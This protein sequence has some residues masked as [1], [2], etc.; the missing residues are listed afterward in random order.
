[1]NSKQTTL[2]KLILASTIVL[3][4]FAATAQLNWPSVT[5]VTKPWTRWWWE[6]SAVNKADLTWNLEQYQQAGLGGVELTPIYGVEGTEKQF[7]D[8]LS[9]K[10]MQ[11]FSY[12]LNESKRLGLGVDLAN[13]TGWPFGGPW[14]KEDDASKSI[15]YKTYKVGGGEQLSEAVEY[16]QEGFIR[17]ANN[18][19]A[20][21]AQ[22]LKP[23]WTNKNL[24]AL[25]LDQIQYPGKLSL[26][27]L[28]A[29]S[30]KNETIDL[31]TKVDAN[32]KLNW[33]A[34]PTGGN[35]T[36]YALFQ[37]LHG[38]MVERAAPGGEGYAI[39]HFS[40]N[41][42][43]NY[44][45]KFDASFKGYDISYLRS[46]FND[47]YE[48]DDARGQSNWTPDFLAEFKKRKGYDLRTQLP[49]L[50]GKDTNEKYSRV[51]YDYRS[52]IDELLLEHFTMTWKKWAGT[53]GKM[54]RNQ[55]HG[56]PANTL[57]LYSVVDIPETEGTD[58]LRFKFATSAA[59]VSGKQLVSSESATWLN[60]HFLS[61]WGDVK[62]AIDLYFL[63]GVNHIFY[64]GTEYSPKE[65]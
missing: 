53:K 20:T 58:I 8:F 21:F 60:E 65:A 13:G 32:G 63:G 5:N 39:D 6:G 34:P 40:L 12:T 25:A 61:S 28:I 18:K 62:K 48:V 22:V 11:M 24:Q 38:K 9:P 43:K 1:M 57:D 45:K 27:T 44:F 15:F 54:L 46:F 64:H 4:A 26:Q 42:A 30:D 35:W 29:Y 36:L 41:A 51:I 50:F 23:V 52:V 47:S 7:I 56:S 14:V 3:N 31:T 19:P 17:T 2:R 10:W 55:S 59:N 16:K 37:G 49:A 33:T